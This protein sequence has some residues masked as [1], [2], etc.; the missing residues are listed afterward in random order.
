MQI[1]LN[2]N[3]QSFREFKIEYVQKVMNE[4]PEKTNPNA[5]DLKDLILLVDKNIADKKATDFIKSTY[6]YKVEVVDKS[7][8]ENAILNNEKGIAFID[9][10]DKSIYR[11]DDLSRI[12]QYFYIPKTKVIVHFFGFNDENIIDL[13]DYIDTLHSAIGN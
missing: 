12:Y 7:R 10:I 11:S 13:N 3:F 6:K 9:N 8:I 2:N 1:A 4:S 5:K